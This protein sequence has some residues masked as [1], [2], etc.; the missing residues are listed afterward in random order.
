M[1]RGLARGGRRV[2]EEEEEEEED[3]DD[4]DA[5]NV[6]EVVSG[7]SPEEMV[8]VSTRRIT[9][10]ISAQKAGGDKDTVDN[11]CYG[12]A[13]GLRLGVLWRA[14]PSAKGLARLQ[15]VDV[16]HRPDSALAL[17][18]GDCAK[19]FR[20]AKV[21]VSIDSLIWAWLAPMTPT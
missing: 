4:V 5:D 11:G 21:Q 9:S 12:R 18:C 7:H 2:V 8:K 6:E 10:L 19:C 15:D 20:R 16:H 3:I 1:K 14:P 17:G 13:E